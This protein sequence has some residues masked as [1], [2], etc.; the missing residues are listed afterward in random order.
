MIKGLT[1]HAFSLLRDVYGLRDEDIDNLDSTVLAQKIQ[2]IHKG[3]SAEHEFAAIAS[4]LGKCS[5][6]S[7]L[8]D[9]LHT[10]GT[11]RTPDF[12]VV[13]NY[14][15]REVPF[16]VEAK[17]E[18]TDTLRWSGNYMDSLRAFA[19]LMNLPLLLAWKRGGLWVLADSTLFSKKVTAY[20]LS[21]EDA[22]KNSLMST[23]FGNVWIKFAEKFRLELTMRIQ[24]DVDF[25]KEPLPEG[26][27]RFLIEDAGLWGS[28]GRLNA[29]QGKDLW[30]FLVTAASETRFDRVDDVATQQ[31]IAGSDSMFNLSD[32]LLAQLRWNKGDEEMIDW[33]AEIRKGLPKLATELQSIL[34]HALDAG[35][36]QYIFR[37]A[38][39]VLPKFLNSRD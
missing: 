31:F 17:S 22:I 35:A 39:Q 34:R 9:V 28:K 36:V 23:L 11:Y 18:D 37:Q 32:V 10:S 12:L 3:L 8:D 14:E 27:Y 29:E 6:L 20:H 2:R 7:H 38:P 26:N 24:D 13:V 25:T 5:L 15:G 1:S 30:W 33:L 19:D 4:W 21:F 16:L